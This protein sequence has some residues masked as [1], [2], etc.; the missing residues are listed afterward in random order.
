MRRKLSSEP[1]RNLVDHFKSIKDSDYIQWSL[2]TEHYMGLILVHYWGLQLAAAPP[3]RQL[4]AH[5]QQ[6]PLL[7]SRYA[8]AVHLS[9]PPF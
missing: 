8:L 9:P 6:E 1:L 2:A 3:H 7:S 5:P 4:P